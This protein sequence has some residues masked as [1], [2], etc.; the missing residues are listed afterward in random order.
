MCIDNSANTRT[1][2]AHFAEKQ[3]NKG[4]SYM[5]SKSIMQMAFFVSGALISSYSV[6]MLFVISFDLSTLLMLM[7]GALMFVPG[8]FYPSIVKHSHARILLSIVLILLCSA[9]ISAA[10]VAFYGRRDN[11]S[12]DED[13]IIVL[14]CGIRG[15]MVSDQLARRLD[16]A[17]RYHTQNPDAMILVSGGQGPQES[18]TE[19]L[20]ME[21]YLIAGGIPS[22]KIIKEESST[23]T[24]SNL[25]FSKEILDRH[26]AGTYK[27]AIVTSD[28]HIYRATKLSEELG[29]NCSHIHSKTLWYEIPARYFRELLAIAKD[30][31][32]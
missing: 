32:L 17:I 25:L 27:S 29:M 4:R 18:V 7:T 5:K 12:Y 9:I 30:I 31:L 8:I 3:K 14:G 22:D 13:V 11:S 21:T 2:S 19:A 23:S 10:V 15:D 28:Y 26:F 16:A 20:A 1:L 6:L 24:Y